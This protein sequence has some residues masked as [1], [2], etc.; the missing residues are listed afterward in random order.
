MPPE[1]SGRSV[2]TATVRL[3]KPTGWIKASSSFTQLQAKS[4][5]TARPHLDIIFCAMRLQVN[6][7]NRGRLLCVD[8]LSTNSN[9]VVLGHKFEEG[10]IEEG[11][12]AS[13]RCFLSWLSASIPVCMHDSWLFAHRSPFHRERDAHRVQAVCPRPC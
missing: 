11:A 7:S 4:R 5:S 13:C 1:G 8:H 9:R 6:R 12:R 2:R 10:A 3:G